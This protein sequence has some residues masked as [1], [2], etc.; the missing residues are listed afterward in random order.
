M[1]NI[2]IVATGSYL[3]PNKVDNEQLANELEVAEQFIYKRTGIKTRY[4]SENETIEQL[5]IKSIHNLIDKKPQINI[6]DIDMIVVA[7]TSTN[8]LM[9]GISYKVQENLKIKNCMC[10]DILA[11]CAG[12]INAID[13]A[14]TYIAIG[15]VNRALVIGVDILSECIDKQDMSTS[16]ILSDGAGAVVVQKTEDKTLYESNIISEGEKG[17]L[18]TYKANEKIK[19]NGK[20]IYKYAVTETITNIN[21][22]LKKSNTDI[23]EIKYIVPHQSNMK[24]MKSIANRLNMNSQKLYMNIENVGNTFCASI[25]IAID[26]MFEKKL[27]QKGDK[28]IL[29]GYGGGLNTGSILM[30]V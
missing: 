25:P 12:F 1:K 4:Y 30:E 5:A 2:E 11:G 10:L 15:K 22:L 19:M 6:D 24:I 3:P 13:I 29:L 21:N 14:R 17:N 20:E 27:L 23:D 18:L 8:L 9:P 16:I 28:I 7:T 26:E